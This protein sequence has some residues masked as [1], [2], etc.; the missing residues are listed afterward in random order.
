MK[1]ITRLFLFTFLSITVISCRKD[2][3]EK[4]TE[5]FSS[6]DNS[7]AE[8][9]FADVFNQLDA[10]ADTVSGLRATGCAIVT[11]SPADTINFPKT[12]TIDFGTGCTGSDGIVRKGKITAKFTGKYRKTGTVI[13]VTLNN[14]YRNDRLI[15]GTKVITNKGVNSA[16]NFYYTISVTDASITG[17][18]GTIYWTSERQREWIEGSSTAAVA[19]DVYLLTGS[20]SGTGTKG[21][22][23]TVIITDALKFATACKWIQSGKIKLQ[24]A[25]LATRFI[26]FG[27]GCDDKATVTI[28]SV[29]REITLN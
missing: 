28:N 23:F 11:L 13:T 21:N 17:P 20:A 14:Y 6:V 7:E 18:N 3:R 4:D 29:S 1:L 9:S 22:T 27:S 16:G 10:V 26:D 12:L 8:T 15:K 2:D 24:P 5:T 19:D 25:N